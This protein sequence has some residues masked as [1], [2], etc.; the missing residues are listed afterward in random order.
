MTTFGDARLPGNSIAYKRTPIFATD[1]VPVALLKAHSTKAGCW[2]LIHVLEG[3]LLYVVDDPRRPASHAML[4]C[5]EPP[6]LIEPT[7]LHR[8][9]PGVG[10]RFQVEFYRILDQYDANEK[11]KT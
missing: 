3:E 10:A 8:V 11:T 2:A 5:G 6:G 9:E 7:I 4:K 1:T